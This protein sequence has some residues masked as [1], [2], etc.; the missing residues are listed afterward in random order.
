TLGIAALHGHGDGVAR[1][2]PPQPIVEL[3]LSGDAHAVH[4]DDAVTAPEAG[5]ARGPGLVE[6]VHHDAVRA[7]A[8]V[9]AEPRPRPTAGHAAGRDQ[10]ILHG[11][12][13]LER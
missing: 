12:E 7:A 3:L 2:P 9:Q 11:Q 13:G 8:R 5:R 4:A 1:L 6:A 10:L